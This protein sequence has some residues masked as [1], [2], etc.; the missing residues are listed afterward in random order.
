MGHPALRARPGLI[1]IF[2]NRVDGS[3]CICEAIWVY[4]RRFL[5]FQCRKRIKLANLGPIPTDG[6]CPYYSTPSG[7]S[8]PSA[9]QSIIYQSFAAAATS[10]KIA[11]K[12]KDSLGG[13]EERGDAKSSSGATLHN[14][15]NRIDGGGLVVGQGRQLERLG[16]VPYCCCWIFAVP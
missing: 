16:H 7:R 10:M 11:A 5:F 3:R 4:A 1:S 13:R 6:R 15:P 9:E 2:C 8:F 14:R 12:G